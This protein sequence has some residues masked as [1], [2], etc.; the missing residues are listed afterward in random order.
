MKV[1]FELKYG[2]PWYFYKSAKPVTP[3]MSPPPLNFVRWCNSNYPLSWSGLSDKNASEIEIQY[4]ELRKTFNANLRANCSSCSNVQCCD[5]ENLS[6]STLPPV[7]KVHHTAADNAE[8]GLADQESEHLV[9]RS[10][11]YL[12]EGQQLTSAGMRKLSKNWETCLCRIQVRL[13][14]I[15]VWNYQNK[16]MRQCQCAGTSKNKNPPPLHVF[17]PWGSGLKI[18]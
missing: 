9:S 12:T 13:F 2:E 5:N 15:S 18:L 11:K 3:A 4:G 14:Y 17:L 6:I 10:N 8:H 16:L 1:K 7:T